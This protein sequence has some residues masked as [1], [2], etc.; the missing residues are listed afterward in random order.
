MVKEF[1]LHRIFLVAICTFAMGIMSIPVPE[2][3]DLTAAVCGFLCVAVLYF[4]IF[5]LKNNKI[6]VWVAAVTSVFFAAMQIGIITEFFSHK[7]LKNTPDILITALFILTVLYACF[8]EGT[9]LLKFSLIAFPIIVISVGII[10]LLSLNQVDSLKFSY[11]VKSQKDLF[12][13]RS[14]K[15]GALFSPVLFSPF[16]SEGANKRKRDD[17]IGLSLGFAVFVVCFLNVSLFLK[18]AQHNDFPYFH[19]TE[20]LSAGGFFTRQTG[21]V[22]VVFFVVSFIKVCLLMQVAESPFKGYRQGIRKTAIVTA[23][24]FATV[25]SYVF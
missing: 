3:G 1:A 14:I 15:Y 13:V 11:L 20:I 9:A 10:L 21:F 8:T 22:Y 17:F 19:I 16:H 23:I 25:L 5:K 6:A 18:G 12:F 2:G 4:F 24:A 7:V